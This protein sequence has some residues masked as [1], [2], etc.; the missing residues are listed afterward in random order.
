[1]PKLNIGQVLSLDKLED[2]MVI[3]AFVCLLLSFFFGL[4]PGLPFA[5]LW[6]CAGISALI[7][8]YF[9]FPHMWPYGLILLAAYAI[10][11]FGVILPIFWY[12]KVTFSGVSI[13]IMAGIFLIA[14]AFYIA[15]YIVQY[16][17]KTRDAL[18]QEGEYLPL[19]FWII[20]VELFV[21]FSVLS[22]FGWTI[23][24]NS[25][26]KDLRYYLILEP[27]IAVL[28]IYILWLPDRNL[29]WSV[30]ELPESP[31]TKFLMDQSKILKGKVTKI[32][33]V[34][35]ECASKLKREKKTCP[36]CDHIQAFGW[37]MTSE[38]YVL[39]CSHCG[40]MA[41]YGKAKCDECGKALFDSIA[42]NA[43]EKAFPIKEWIART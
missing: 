13:P 25:G 37:C 24:V 7:G 9:A 8:I 33:N 11:A 1:M 5:I 36:S 35:P 41:L 30:E 3:I 38:A 14:A 4:Q 16:V 31:A 32:R 26:E 2:Q 17:K 40:S 19:G 27:L 15:F 39:P 10:S 20:S 12:D 43:C 21:L 18:P 6:A 34:C 22:I 42:C 28:L 23:W 29:D